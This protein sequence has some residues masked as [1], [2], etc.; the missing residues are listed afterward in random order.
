MNIRKIEKNVLATMNFEDARPSKFG[1]K[2]TREFLEGNITSKQA[3]KKI[4]NHYLGGK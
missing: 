1:Q 3:I 4:K 2:T